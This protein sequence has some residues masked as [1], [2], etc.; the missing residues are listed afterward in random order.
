MSELG[1]RAGQTLGVVTCQTLGDGTGQSWEA[2]RSWGRDR[3]DAG[4]RDEDTG[5]Y[6]L[7]LYIKGRDPI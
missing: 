5:Q 3:S 2:V 7:L 4:G 1:D 6:L